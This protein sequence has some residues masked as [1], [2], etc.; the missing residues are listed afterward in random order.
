MTGTVPLKSNAV[1]GEESGQDPCNMVV[2]KI[3]ALHPAPWDPMNPMKPIPPPQSLMELT[4]ERIRDAI[5]QGELPL[6]SKVSEQKLADMLQ[7]SR[8]P[9]RKALALLQSEGLVRV[10]PKRG[11]FVFA[12]DEKT[13]KDLCDHRAA[14]ETACLKFAIERNPDALIGGL[15]QGLDQM[16][17]AIAQNEST[18]YSQADL[19]FH[20]TIIQSSDNQSMAK[21]Y[22][23]TIGPLMALRTHFFTE[24]NASLNRSMAEHATLLA[25]CAN[26]DVTRALA[27]VTQHVL[28]L[29]GHSAGHLA[30]HFAISNTMGE[31]QTLKPMR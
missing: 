7:I 1:H 5:I 2:S 13:V 10:L 20:R 18:A 26:K 29:A 4:A 9:V 27:V 22:D 31:P 11:S 23:T 15:R 3:H 24:M 19:R 6:G 25:A 21:V 30:G 16:Q 17:Q 12:P 28:H 8:S 14:L